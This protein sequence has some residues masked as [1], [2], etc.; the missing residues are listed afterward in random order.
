M[1]ECLPN[2]LKAPGSIPSISNKKLGGE[3]YV[4]IFK[5]INALNVNRFFM[6]NDY[7]SKA[8]NT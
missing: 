1:V 6:K 7:F 4:F 5:I 2:T 8:K 3:C